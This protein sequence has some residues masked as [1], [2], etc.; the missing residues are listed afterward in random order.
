MAT[1]ASSGSGSAASATAACNDKAA[2]Y[3]D[4]TIPDDTGFEQ[5]V[6]FTKTWRFRNEGDCTWD[7][8]YTMVFAGGEILNGPLSAPL[9]MRVAPGE[10]ANLSIDLRTPDRGGVFRSNWEFQNPQ[11]ARF[12]TGAGGHEPFWAQV[13]VSWMPPGGGNS[14]GSGSGS[15]GNAGQLT[16]HTACHAGFWGGLPHCHTRGG[17]GRRFRLWN[18][19]D[20]LSDA[21]SQCRKQHRP[22]RA[23]QLPG[24]SEPRLPAGASGLDQSG[25]C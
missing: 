12:G 2:F 11:G 7:E 21:R 20:S 6:G 1:A 24:Q 10:I 3:G 16:H 9:S 25:A 4:V 14:G 13:I 19:T 23:C 15:G 17:L 5:G 22:R 8:T 18:L